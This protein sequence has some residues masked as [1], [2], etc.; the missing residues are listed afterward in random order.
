MRLLRR[1]TEL[2]E[3]LSIDEAFLDITGSRALFGDGERI[4]RRIKVEVF[5]EEQLT[6]SVGVA[7]TKFVAKIAS[8]LQKPDGLVVVA[9]GEVGQ[10]LAPLPVARLWGAGTQTIAQLNRL[11]ARS[12]GDVAKLP[13]ENLVAAFGQ[14]LGNHLFR[15][16]RGIDPREVV[17][18]HERKSVGRESTFDSDVKDRNVVERTL[19]GLV[20]EVARRLRRAGLG[21]HTVTVKLRTA[22]FVTVTRQEAL[23][24]GADTV[25][26]IWPIARRLLAKADTS[27]LP[28]RLVG[29]ALSHFAEDPQLTL[30]DS[31]ASGRHRKVAA[32]MDVLTERFGEGAVRR[33]ALL[34]GR[35]PNGKT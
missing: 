3:P 15:L 2:V 1:Y 8:D 27:S 26:A 11:G 22:D 18:E 28:I 35:Q 7:P 16:A 17:A 19:L 10:F 25:E 4:A 33:G 24:F 32:A 31:E 21:G 29:V 14:S 9:P 12:I 34:E 6:A 30:F 5:R 20:E 13:G 23:P